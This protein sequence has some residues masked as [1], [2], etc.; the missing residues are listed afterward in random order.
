MQVRVDG[1]QPVG[2]RREELRERCGGEGLAVPEAPVLAQIAEVRRDDTYACRAQLSRR[3]GREHE[4]QQPL[5]R[6]IKAAD[7]ERVAAPHR[8]VQPHIALAVREASQHERSFRGAGISGRFGTPTWLST[9]TGG[10][11]FGR[12]ALS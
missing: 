2:V 3:A 4:R 1:H 9:R 12:V 6:T 8:R 11:S 7:E 5:V 10:R